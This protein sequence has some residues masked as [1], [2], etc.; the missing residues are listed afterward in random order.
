MTRRTVKWFN[1]EKG[2]GQAPPAATAMAPPRPGV[3]LWYRVRLRRSHPSSVALGER[4]GRRRTF[5]QAPGTD[6]EDGCAAHVLT[7]RDLRPS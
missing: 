4:R 6:Q 7:G 2:F 5:R 1:A 3:L